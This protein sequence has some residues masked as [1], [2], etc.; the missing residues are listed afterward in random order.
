MSAQIVLHPC[1]TGAQIAEWC[2]RQRMQVEIRFCRP[3][4]GFL[5]VEAAPI[6][7]HHVVAIAPLPQETVP[8]PL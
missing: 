3:H 1:M 6:I 5:E 8:C 7:D 4:V 2:Q